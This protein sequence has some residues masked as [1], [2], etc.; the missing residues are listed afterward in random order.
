[1]TLRRAYAPMFPEFDAFLFAAVGEEVDGIPLSV[2]SA[3]SRLGL[4]PRDEA[5]RLAHL[6]KDAAADQLARMIARLADRQW[7]VAEA[8]RI[9]S[10]LIERLP[11]ANAAGKDD[12]ATR[13]AKPT[14]LFR[15]PSY[16]IY[17][18]LAAAMLVSLVAS[19][20]LSLNG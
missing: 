7:S 16:L 13:G 10:G 14:T 8:R 17:L 5:A 18:A 6:T 4:D 3:L 20:Y 11:M 12:R 1:M 19:G 15:A 2:L 9:A